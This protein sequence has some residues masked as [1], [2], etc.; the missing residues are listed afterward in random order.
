MK[1]TI[2]TPRDGRVSVVDVPCP[3]LHAGSVLVANHAS[4]ISVGTERTKVEMGEKSLLQKARARP[5]LVKKVVDRARSEG[6][7]STARVTQDRL[8]AF[9]P[10]GYSAAGVVIE[11][12][13]GV[14]GLAPGDRVACGGEGAN[15]AEILAVPRNLVARIPDGVAFEDAAYATVGAIA[16][17]GV[18]QAD[19]RIGEWVGVIGLGLVGQLA[20]RM[21]RASGCHVVGIDVDDVAV[22]SARTA[23]LTAF[24]RD[25]SGLAAAIHSLTSGLG[26]DAVVLCASS[27]ST[28]PLALAVQLARDRGRIVLVG[29]TRIDVDRAPMYEKELE[30]R[31][32]RSYGP[33]RYD[34]EYEERGRDLPAGY[35]RWTEQRNMQAFL[36]LVGAGRVDPSELTTHRFPIDDAADA[37]RIIAHPEEGERAFGVLL[38]YKMPTAPPPA[39]A[40]PRARRPTDRLGVAVIGPGAFARATLIPAL[41]ADGARLVAVASSRGL[42]AAD[43]ATRFGFERAAASPNEILAD[44]SVDA[45]VIAT[46]HTSHASLAA[47][48]LRAGKAVFVEK[49]LALNWEQLDDVESALTPDSVL[50]VG[51]NR[52]FAPL[53]ERLQAE[54]GQVD[55][56]VVSM[57][58]NAGRLPDDHWLHD[59]EDGG[60]RLLGEGCH[61]VDLLSHVCH[62]DVI[63]AH[64]VAVPQ[65][66]RPIECSDSFT[67]HIRFGN[68]V[69][70]LVYSGGGDPKLPKERLEV[71]GGGAAAVLDDFRVLTIHRA[72]KRRQWKSSHDKGHRAEVRRFLAAAAGEVE[73]PTARSY[74]DSTRLTLAL[75]S[76]LRTGSP[77][78]MSA[79]AEQAPR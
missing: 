71:F 55:D 27:G 52:R 67:A 39:P 18:R 77:V 46:R 56:L 37:Y 76:S 64:A 72:G 24:A 35:V 6:I 19:A 8:S 11:V 22:E 23:Q 29:E 28:D 45:V 13:L 43:V 54:L 69:G 66:G 51:F 3:A 48:A 2:Q 53:V 75:A 16:L 14:Y 21:A 1:Q 5:D 38:T 12:G 44:D 61:F 20:A 74:L 31:M 78:D 42:T 70:T 60:G 79:E 41:R 50:I 34:R 26:L 49:P 36:D 63:S 40:V 59:P 4:L 65:P 32:S 68:A 9:T 33:G 57:R 62:S 25:D 15:H 30:L 10:I 73:P 17:H 7:Q 58:V 47:A